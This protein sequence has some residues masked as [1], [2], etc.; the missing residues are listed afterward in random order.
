MTDEHTPIRSLLGTKPNTPLSAFRPRL[1]PLH[2]QLHIDQHLTLL[3]WFLRPHHRF[4]HLALRYL[5]PLI[6]YNLCMMRFRPGVYRR[7]VTASSTLSSISLNTKNSL[8]GSGT[9]LGTV[10]F[11]MKRVGTRKKI[12]ALPWNGARVEPHVA[13]QPHLA[14]PHRPRK[15]KAGEC[16]PSLPNRAVHPSSKLSTHHVTNSLGD[17]LDREWPELL[18]KD[19]GIRSDQCER[20]W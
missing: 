9:H 4:S 10:V 7:C 11:Q 12:E 5:P 2:P 1:P 18:E 13:Q 20:D 3:P 16:T 6:P 17:P 15:P 14:L 8:M 19:S